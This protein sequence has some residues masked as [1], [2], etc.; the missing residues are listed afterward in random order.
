MNNAHLN[1]GFLIPPFV[2]H[3]RPATVLARALARRGHRVQII[4]YPDAMAPLAKA[5]VELTTFGESMFPP[6]EWDRRVGSLG[7]AEGR[8]IYLQVFRLILDQCRCLA[9]DLPATLKRLKL[10]GLVVD[11]LCYGAE[12]VAESLGVPMVVAC[13]ALPFHR[14]SGVPQCFRP[15]NYNPALWARLR[16]KAEGAWN[17]LTGWRMS[18]FYL[19]H[20]R[21]LG[22]R[23]PALSHINEI[24]PSLAQVAQIP[25]FFDFPR[26]RLPDHFHYTGPWLEPARTEADDF[27]WAR[28]N[29]R[30]L[31]YASLGTL[32][33]RVMR[34]YGIIAAACEGLDVQLVIG[35]G[36]IS[37]DVGALLPELP[38]RT[39]VAHFAPQRELISRA[40]LVITHAGLNSTL[41]TLS[42]GV[43]I[44]AV[45]ISH[46]QPGVAA[47]LRHL[48]A[49][50]VISAAELTVDRLRPAI[51]EVMQTSSFGLRA[52][53]C[54][55]SLHEINGQEL[56][57]DVIERA[58][59][60]GQR[61]VRWK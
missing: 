43:P 10:D 41:E 6:G 26:R 50:K 14:E 37:E 36:R 7:A 61:T 3:L 45:P 11:Q 2:G 33:N 28:L 13:N 55:R 17:I 48:G 12:S 21:A 60:T 58:F 52:R 19:K 15:W 1:I 20:R 56:A 16:N 49:G 51:A 54:A 40:A 4:S 57:A 27:P 23:P 35:L 53:E 44:V 39:I 25:K 29:G 18:V 32:Q 24:P 59:Q 38:Q 22:L 47:R 8:E 5:G 9:T 46:D 31:I 30:P 42:A 34:W